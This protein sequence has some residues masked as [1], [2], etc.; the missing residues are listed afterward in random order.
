MNRY[1]SAR[2]KRLNAIFILT[3]AII[4][5]VTIPAL[6]GELKNELYIVVG[7]NILT[8]WLLLFIILIQMAF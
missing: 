1:K 6:M 3:I 2:S 5:G 4:I 8:L 7:I